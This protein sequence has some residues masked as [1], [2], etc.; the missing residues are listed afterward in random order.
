MNWSEFTALTT[1]MADGRAEPCA[2]KTNRALNK[3]HL[4]HAA[5]CWQRFAHACANTATGV[6]PAALR[7]VPPSPWLPPLP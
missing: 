4:I 1:A 7:P 3:R 6:G 2:A 5:H